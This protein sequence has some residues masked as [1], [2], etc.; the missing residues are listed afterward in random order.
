M[1]I[2]NTLFAKLRRLAKRGNGRE[3][4]HNEV[5][6]NVGMFSSCTSN[7]W[8]L[9]DVFA[10]RMTDWRVLDPNVLANVPQVYPYGS[11]S[12]S[13]QVAAVKTLC[14]SQEIPFDA[15]RRTF[16]E[17]FQH[18]ASAPTLAAQRPHS[19]HI[20]Q[21]ALARLGSPDLEVNR[22]RLSRKQSTAQLSTSFS[23][24]DLIH[25]IFELSDRSS[26][27]QSNAA[28]YD[29]RCRDTQNL[30]PRHSPLS[31]QIPKKAVLPKR[32]LSVCSPILAYEERRSSLSRKPDVSNLRTASDYSHVRSFSLPV[33]SNTS[34]PRSIARSPITRA[35][36]DK[37]LP[38]V[39]LGK[40]NTAHDI[41]RALRDTRRSMSRMLP[42]IDHR[43][44]LSPGSEDRES[45]VD[46]T[47]YRTWSP[48]VTHETITRQVHD[49][50]EEYLT[51]NI[52]E[53]DVYYRTLPIVD[54]EVLPARHYVPSETGLIEIAED[55]V[56]A[57]MRPSDEWVRTQ[58]TSRVL[59]NE[60]EFDN[61][62]EATD[63]GVA[64][65]NVIAPLRTPGF[66]HIESTYHHPAAVGPAIPGAERM[67][68][69][70]IEAS[71]WCQDS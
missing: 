16:S 54:V 2:S 34:R 67:Y 3:I 26:L 25:S 37:P 63:I 65:A 4:I 9:L 56:P 27:N 13:A 59:Q 36:L 8:T 15:H 64:E 53:H 41:R 60:N 52:H 42:P 14:P 47:Y 6:T 39:P 68:A 62:E 32:P 31:L 70:S 20:L 22:R 21:N 33:H 5:A 55:D 35:D 66:R 17:D 48:A 30:S 18:F 1:A 28:M 12:L 49:I 51:R 19:V 43:L 61:V 58:A 10:L 11:R 40:E 69:V 7:L 50:R 57:E 29:T 46:T 23:N 45:K 71:G 24:G 44:Q 38:P